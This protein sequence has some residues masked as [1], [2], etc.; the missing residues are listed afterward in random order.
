M[1]GS[2]ASDFSDIKSNYLSLKE[3][4]A[5]YKEKIAALE[6]DLKKWVHL[7]LSSKFLYFLLIFSEV[8]Y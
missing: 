7:A 6:A 1:S 2:D 5:I 3:N 4:C 8:S